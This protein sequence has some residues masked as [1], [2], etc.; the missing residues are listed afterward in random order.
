[1]NEH[2]LNVIITVDTEL[3]PHS[4]GWREENLGVDFARDIDGKTPEGEFGIGYQLDVLKQYGLKAVFYVESLF[5]SVV[6]IDLLQLTSKMI[7]DA[8]QEVQLHVHPEWLNYMDA[9]YPIKTRGKFLWQ[10]SR[11]E[12][13]FLIGLGL[14][15]IK[16]TGITP[17]A[18]R[19]GN[20]GANF[21]TLSAL[22]DTGILY[23]S[24]YNYTFL[25]S[26]CLIKT[27][28]MLMQPLDLFGVCEVPITFFSDYPGHYRHAQLC[29]CSS[30]EM[31]NLLLDA[32]RNRWH[33]VVIVSHSFE[34]IKRNSNPVAA[35]KLV[36]DRY[37]RLCRFIASNSDKFSTVHFSEMSDTLCRTDNTEI[38]N[39]LKSTVISTIQRN[40]QQA[41]NR[42]TL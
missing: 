38:L 21:D 19:A 3:W 6:G 2:T 15:N 1:M 4:P 13:K 36:I 27:D 8:G 12:Q 17:I 22:A 14:D 28:K 9:D 23:D 32:W 18:F 7:T 16:K 41:L 20:Y 40:C 30:N 29:A 10:F 34:L 24:S 31:E 33:Y 26:Q 35:N 11:E 5:A 39:P 42:F 37:E 25:D